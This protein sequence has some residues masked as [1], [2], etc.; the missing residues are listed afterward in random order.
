MV[1]RPDDLVEFSRQAYSKS[2][3]IHSFASDDIVDTGLDEN[4]LSLLEK[5]TVGDGKLLII[6]IGGG[7][8][9]IPLAQKGFEVTGI[10]FVSDMITL[11]EENAK[12]R[13]VQ[14]SG[15]IQSID[16]LELADYSFDVVWFSKAM[17]SSV[18]TRERRLEMLKRIRMALKPHGYLICQFLCNCKETFSPKV[19]LMRKTIALFTLGNLRYERGDMLFNHTEFAHSFASEQELMEEFKAG[20]FEISYVNFPDERI[21]GEAILVQRQKYNLSAAV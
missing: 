21:T 14:I 20:G 7:R 9:A 3:N 19:E 16:R 10:D 18:P 6:G 4:E 11:A 1:M 2:K 8:E 5:I 17:Y 13:G 12:K 15:I